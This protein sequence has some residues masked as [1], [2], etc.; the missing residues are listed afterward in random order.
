MA[1]LVALPLAAA[2]L[3][4][5]WL[6]SALA[7][8]IAVTDPFARASAGAA[9]VGAAFMTV[10]NH[11]SAED[12][13]VSASSPVAERVELHTHIRDGEVMRMREIDAIE[14]PAGGT[15]KLQPGGLHL[16]LIDLTAP[17]KQ[18]ETFPL[19]LSF[20]HAG[21]MTVQVPVQTPA[22]M[23]PMPHGH[24]MPHGQHR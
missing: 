12:R 22:A 4:V 18:G 1:Q 20:E 15:V 7:A 2:A 21:A 8:D 17:L 24:D 6:G 3:V 11:G 23:A 14:I 10:Q 9:K 16:M 19:T 13:L 5:S